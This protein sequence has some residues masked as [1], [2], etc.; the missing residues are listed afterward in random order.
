MDKEQLKL[1]IDV[2]AIHE[3]DDEDDDT[4]GYL[5]NLNDTWHWACGDCEEIEPEEVAEIYRLFTHYGYYGAYYWA[6]LKRD[7]QYTDFL[8]NNRGIDFVRHEEELVRQVPGSS[9]R[10]LTDLNYCLG[11]TPA[12]WP[13]VEEKPVGLIIALVL[14]MITALTLGVLRVVDSF[15]AYK[16]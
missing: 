9:K 2:G 1:L 5:L 10:A 8:D 14:S 13:C 3:L 16:Q 12:N 7:K 4:S 6:W 15:L 11:K